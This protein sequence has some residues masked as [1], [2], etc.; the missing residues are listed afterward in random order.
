LQLEIE[1]RKMLRCASC[2]AAQLVI[3]IVV[4]MLRVVFP[5]SREVAANGLLPMKDREDPDELEACA[6]ISRSEENK[7]VITLADAKNDSV[8]NIQFEVDENEERDIEECKQKA[9]GS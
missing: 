7:S 3:C 8:D 5:S 2:C 1:L 4:S 6:F 9:S